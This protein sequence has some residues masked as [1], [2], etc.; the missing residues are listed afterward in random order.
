MRSTPFALGSA[1][2]ALSPTFL[3][4]R[5]ARA[6]IDREVRLRAEQDLRI[7]TAQPPSSRECLH[8]VAGRIAGTPALSPFCDEPV[9]AARIVGVVQGRQIDDAWTA[10][11]ELHLETEPSMATE[12]CPRVS[13]AWIDAEPR[14]PLAVGSLSA[15][16]RARLAAYL[17]D[18]AL[19]VTDATELSVVLVREGDGLIVTG[20]A[21]TRTVSDGYRGS[22]EVLD[23]LEAI[24]ESA[25]QPAAS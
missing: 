21:S 19:E 9:L 2:R 20:R 15:E 18:R 10:P 1:L 25:E 3:L 11:G 14:A 4:G 7:R 8:R 24:V 23:V 22:V 13:I 12:R 17:F 16:A 6:R 5:D